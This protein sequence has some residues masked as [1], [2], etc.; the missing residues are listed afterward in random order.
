[1]NSAI[2]PIFNKSF[3]EKNVCG[4]HEQCTGPIEQC[5]I[6]LMA[7]FSTKKKKKERKAKRWIFICI[8]TDTK[9]VVCTLAY[10]LYQNYFEF[11]LILIM[12]LDFALNK[13]SFLLQ[14]NNPTLNFF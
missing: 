12:C 9:G 1:M 14:V 7:L 2:G 5:I 11:F 8:Q 4:S 13:L 3:V 10:F 6:P